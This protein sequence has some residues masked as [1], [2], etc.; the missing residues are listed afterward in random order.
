MPKVNKLTIKGVEY[1]IDA[2]MKASFDETTKTLNLTSGGST[3]ETT[4]S[5]ATMDIEVDYLDVINEYRSL[6]YVEECYA[7]DWLVVVS[8]PISEYVV[9]M[10][11]NTNLVC[12]RFNYMINKKR[13]EKNEKNRK[14]KKRYGFANS[15]FAKDKN[16]YTTSIKP[17]KKKILQEN[18]ISIT[19]DD[20]RVKTNVKGERVYYIHKIVDFSGIKAK[21]T[22]KVGNSNEFKQLNQ[23]AFE[24]RATAREFG[25][26]DWIDVY[27]NRNQLEGYFRDGYYNQAIESNNRLFDTFEN[28]ERISKDL[29]R[30]AKYYYYGAR[31]KTKT[32][33][34]FSDGFDFNPITKYGTGRDRG[35]KMA[36]CIIHFL[37]YQPANE[38]EI[39]TITFPPNPYAKHKQPIYFLHNSE[40]NSGETR[41]IRKFKT[42][43]GEDLRGYRPNIGTY[44]FEKAKVNFVILKPDWE[45]EVDNMFQYVS[46]IHQNQILKTRWYS[47]GRNGVFEYN[48][49]DEIY[50]ESVN[51]AEMLIG[52]TLLEN[53]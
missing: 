46:P 12:V 20:I 8:K 32:N 31:V 52:Y 17:D 35:Q 16:G 4:S 53:D 44:L 27:E 1:E 3:E 50:F 38:S 22:I 34:G 9:N 24:N 13:K 15:F 14:L 11:K 39:N 37:D 10:I 26:I 28:L 5:S 47:K 23:N 36:K 43:N 7:K 21:S 33:T 18:L 30:F 19:F 51:G 2:G 48:S 6:A 45:N 29:P 40:I 42:D 49:N 41:V 25:V